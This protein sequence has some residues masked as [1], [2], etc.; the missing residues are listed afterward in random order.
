MTS[1]LFMFLPQAM[2]LRYYMTLLLIPSLVAVSGQASRLRQ[3]MRWII[4]AGVW[5]G[6]FASFLQP[7]YYWSK[8]GEWINARGFLSPNVYSR[9][10]AREECIQRYGPIP[11]ELDRTK[12]NVQTLMACA[13]RLRASDLD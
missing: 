2:E 10:P 8:T 13:I 5:L 12:A 1:F 6:L 9:L 3:L 7:L 11:T 4:V